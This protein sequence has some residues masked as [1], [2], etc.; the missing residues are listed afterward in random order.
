MELTIQLILFATIALVV[1]IAILIAVVHKVKSQTVDRFLVKNPPKDTVILHQYGASPTVPSISPYVIKL[2]TYLKVAKIPYV[3]HYD[4][5][6]GPKGK[7]PWIQFNEHVIPDT[8]FIIQFLNKK[9]HIDL[10]KNL[11]REQLAIGHMARRTVEESLYW[12]MLTFRLV[13]EKCGTI[14]KKLG[15]PMFFIWYMRATAKGRLF[16]H[17][18]S[19]HSEDEVRQLME[20]DLS[21]ISAILG[22]KRF[23]FGNSVEDVTEFDCAVFGQL[24]QMVWQ[25]PDCHVEDVI[26]GN[27]PNL[28]EYCTRMK[29]EFWADWEQRL[30]KQH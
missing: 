19:R 17:G 26:A 3:N 11:S 7:L 8:H 30:L 13:F 12:I 16:S 21:A 6:P 24:C 20:D 5:K 27:F 28:V 4:R 23:L 25:M 22:Q 2:E 29:T 9:F 1:L 15:L 10:N 14:Y 18:I